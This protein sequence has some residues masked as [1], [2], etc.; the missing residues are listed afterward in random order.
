MTAPVKPKASRRELEGE[1]AALKQENAKLKTIRDALIEQADRG[2][3]FG[4]KTSR[5]FQSVAELDASVE[6]RIQRLARAMSEAKIARRQLRHAIDSISEGF[7]LYDE[8]DRIVL[9][10]SKYRTLFPE[11]ANLLEPGTP[12]TDIIHRAAAAGVVAEAVTHPEA[13]I[14]LRLEHHKRE[15]C[16]FQQLLSDGRWIQI[17]EQSTREGGKVTVVSDITHFKLLEETRRLTKLTE[18]SDLL[19]RTVASI[20]QGVV[21]FDEEL[22]LV[23]WNSQAAMLLNLPYVEMHPGM[24]VRDLFLLVH[25]HG[26]RLPLQRRHEARDWINNAKNRYPLRLEL[27]YSGGRCVA[28]NFR[29][30]PEDGFVI[31]MT[32]VSAQIKAA[33][34]LAQSKEQLE[35]HVNER[36]RA[37]QRLNAIFQ[38]EIRRHEGTA[39]DLE[40]MRATAEAAN[41]GKTRF[42]AAA[43]H[44]LLQPLNAAR[45][46][47]SALETSPFVNPEARELLDNTLQAFASIEALL[48]TLLDI[49]KMDA[50]GYQPKYAPVNLGEL[51]ETL[52][53]EFGAQA[54]QKGLRLRTVGSSIMVRSDARLLRSMVQNLVSNAVKYT[55]SGSVLLGARRRGDLLTIEV[56]DTGPGIASENHEVIFEEF[57]RLMPASTQAGGLGLGLAT[58]RRAAALLGYQVTLRS[59]LGGSTCFSILLPWQPD[60]SRGAA[61]SGAFEDGKLERMPIPLQEE[62]QPAEGYLFVL[63][64]DH[65]VA[66][67]MTTLFEHWRLKSITAPSYSALVDL[68][69]SKSLVPRA[70]IADLHLDD[71][72]DGIEAIRL[73]RERTGSD[74]PGI[75]V[76]ADQTRDIQERAKELGIEYFSK[77]VKPAQ[78]RAYLFHLCSD[79]AQ[80]GISSGA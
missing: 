27:L 5:V 80:A 3:D 22:K 52:R 19:V 24:S 11:L 2:H 4:G 41:L 56:H 76:T 17:S 8:N 6:K 70:I 59:S 74:L 57:K 58:V 23:A 9:C 33:N 28:A 78:L 65:G 64:N 25:K 45:L 20:A 30:M 48:S 71:D 38:D 12:F 66:S 7:I 36:T 29:D 67:A 18:Q 63:E 1:L 21:V 75:L 54:R 32:D 61:F 15:S 62:L 51:F 47:L 31:T 34:L 73:L 53:T 39:A 55:G 43:S 50:G 10:N 37:L 69:E 46:Y 35:Q 79:P 77:P 16:Q 49:S 44:D 72:I 14:A 40:R 60:A 42:L 26:A 68:M 13:W